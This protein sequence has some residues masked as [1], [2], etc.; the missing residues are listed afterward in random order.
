MIWD[1]RRDGGHQLAIVRGFEISVA[2][3]QAL[4]VRIECAEVQ[5]QLSGL[6]TRQ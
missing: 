5:E 4:A 6:R 1:R 2:H 3:N